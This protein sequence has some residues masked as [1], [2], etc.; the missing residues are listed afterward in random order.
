M[1][2]K[3]GETREYITLGHGPAKLTNLESIVQHRQVDIHKVCVSG[4]KG[5]KTSQSKLLLGAQT[6]VK[7]KF[8]SSLKGGK[9]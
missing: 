8:P 4:F 2:G 7:G 3:R 9:W 6:F 1:F 5:K